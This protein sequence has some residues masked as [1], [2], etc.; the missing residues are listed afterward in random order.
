MDEKLEEFDVKF[1][2]IAGHCCLG[3]ENIEEMKE[4]IRANFSEKP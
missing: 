3:D 2:Y 4:W 1:S